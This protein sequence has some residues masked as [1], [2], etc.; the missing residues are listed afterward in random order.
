MGIA[1]IKAG[2]ASAQQKPPSCS[3]KTTLLTTGTTKTASEVPSELDC[4]KE[5]ILGHPSSMP[6]GAMLIPGGGGS[7]EKDS[8]NQSRGGGAG[9]VKKPAVGSSAA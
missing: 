9:Q 3:S 6:A 4:T 5:S 8:K 7:S 2:Q 1:Q